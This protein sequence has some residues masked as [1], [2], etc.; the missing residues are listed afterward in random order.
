MTDQL[1]ER[2]DPLWDPKQAAIGGAIIVLIILLLQVAPHL[3]KERMNK[4]K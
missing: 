3:I 4:S 1:T 2:S